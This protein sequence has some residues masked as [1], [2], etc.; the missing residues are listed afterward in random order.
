MILFAQAMLG[1]F[2]LSLVLAFI[3]FAIED[4]F[5]GLKYGR[6]LKRKFPDA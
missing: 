2:V 4:F 1:A 3:I 6:R 5:I